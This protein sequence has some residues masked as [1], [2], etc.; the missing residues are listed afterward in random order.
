M[1]GV[2]SAVAQRINFHTWQNF[3][4]CG[5]QAAGKI[6]SASSL[7]PRCSGVICVPRCLKRLSTGCST[8]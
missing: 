4:G 8:Q 7:E 2:P 3:G 1:I 5:P 6:I